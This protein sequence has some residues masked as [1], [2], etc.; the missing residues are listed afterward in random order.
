MKRLFVAIVAILF[1]SM[2]VSAADL[3]LEWI[4]RSDNE[5][6]FNIERATSQ[7]GPFSAIGKVGPNVTTYKDGGLP[8]A[9]NFCYRVNAANAAGPSAYSNTACAITKAIFTVAKAGTGKGTVS[10]AAPVLNC[11][12]SCAGASAELD[13]NSTL[14]L[15]AAPAQGSTFSGWSGA[16][17][18]S[19]PCT[20]EM[21]AAKTVTASF[22]LIPMPIPPDGLVVKGTFTGTFT[23][24]F[25]LTPAQ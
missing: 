18:G 4:D 7:A 1:L 21:N 9:T 2:S 12:A 25:V 23:G 3:T 14:T 11:D 20:V 19:G 17:T 22:D 24:T 13:G 6:V 10:S 5:D 8:Q 15:I 16:C